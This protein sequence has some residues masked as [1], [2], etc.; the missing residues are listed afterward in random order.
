MT[1]KMFRKATSILVVVI[2]LSILTITIQGTGVFK[3][4]DWPW[5]GQTR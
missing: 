5:K 4:I 3:D 1:M 2:L